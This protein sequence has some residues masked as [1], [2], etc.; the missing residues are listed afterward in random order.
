MS[1]NLKETLEAI[2]SAIAKYQAEIERGKMLERL[3]VNPDFKAVI[4]DGYI[5]AEAT[6]LFNILIDPSGASPYTDEVIQRKLA[7]ICDFKEHVGTSEF[8]GTIKISAKRAVSDL[9][10][11]ESYRDEVTEEFA[12][13][14]E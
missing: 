1:N 7:S 12:K 9:L 8:D 10:R 4:L 5:E 11:E 2:D 6:K 3:M 13:G 14:G